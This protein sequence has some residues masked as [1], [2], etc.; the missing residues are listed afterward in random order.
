MFRR[1]GLCLVVLGALAAVPLASA[2][3]PAPYALQGGAGVLS[4]DGSMHFVPSAAGG[5]RSCAR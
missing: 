5:R 1:F 3:F 2:A 4:N